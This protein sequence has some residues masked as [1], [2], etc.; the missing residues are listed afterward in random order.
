[1]LA[2]ETS[3]ASAEVVKIKL[4][5]LAPEG[6]PWHDALRDMAEEW[7]QIS[8]GG[9]EVTIF[10][11][12]VIGDEPSMV[13]KMRIGQLQAGGLSGAGLHKIATEVQA[14]QMPM[15]FRSDN[16][17]ACVREQIRPT[18]EAVLE[19]AGFKVLTWSD[20]GWVYF[21]VKSPV[22]KPE[23]LIGKR[24]FVWAG[25]T[26]TVEAWKDFGA[27]PVPLPATEIYQS[28]QSGLIEAVPTTPIAALSYQWF[29]L[30]P[31]MTDVKWAPLVG[32]LVITNRAWQQIPEEL[33]PRLL[34]AAEKTGERLRAQTPAF[35]AEAIEV[36]QQ[37]GLLVEP[38]PA[39]IVAEWERQARAGYD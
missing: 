16:E 9:V 1:M 39:N 22:V 2:G 38:V 33:R 14:L 35:E 4:G 12:G 7:K 10:A 27:E 3:A 21:F 37:H 6:S 20:A 15:M 30:A 8:N 11:G 17:L 36:M 32:A 5:T 18:L 13:Q 26:S 25:D 31:H 29:P 28:L 24:L 23:D 34:A 19:Q